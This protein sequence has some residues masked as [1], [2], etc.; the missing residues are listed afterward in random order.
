MFCLFFKLVRVGGHC[1]QSILEQAIFVYLLFN[2]ASLVSRCTE[3]NGE[4][5]HLKG[6]ILAAALG[7]VGV[8]LNFG[9]S[10][11]EE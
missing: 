8:F 11:A 5:Y 7:M 9:H 6:A 10:G 4:L 2:C 1:W 3:L